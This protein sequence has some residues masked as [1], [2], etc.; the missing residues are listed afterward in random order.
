MKPILF[1]TREVQATLG[2]RMT[3]VWRV[4]KPQ[5]IIYGLL[6]SYWNWSGIKPTYRAGDI[7]YVRETWCKGR[8]NGDNERYFYKADSGREFH[9]LW[10]PSTNMPK[11]AARIFLRVTNVS[12]TRLHDILLSEYLSNGALLSLE[13]EMYNIHTPVSAQERTIRVWN[14][15]IKKAD[16]PRYGWDANPWVEVTKFDRISKE[17]AENDKKRND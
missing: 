7:L 16:L 15:T 14:S 9:C 12:V 3:V 17:E 5:P 1:S 10:S 6:E 11:E 13:N 2:G 4:I 8:I